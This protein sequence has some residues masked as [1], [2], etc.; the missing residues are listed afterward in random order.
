MPPKTGW[1]GTPK[2][3][4][5][6]EVTVTEKGC[7][8]LPHKPDKKT[9]YTWFWLTPERKIMK[10]HRASWIIFNGEIPPKIYVCH[11]CDNKLCVNPEH[12]FLGTASDNMKDAEKKGRLS[13]YGWSLKTSCI[14]GHE[15]N[16]E[17]TYFHKGRRHCKI[18]RRERDHKR[19]ER[20]RMKITLQTNADT[21][22]AKRKVN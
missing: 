3:R 9:G 6:S 15:F 7:W 12:L 17:N 13:H 21:A 1:K 20:K 2:Q 5:L 4:L 22:I 10:A 18:C 19:Y 11:K 16:T 14:H 8:E